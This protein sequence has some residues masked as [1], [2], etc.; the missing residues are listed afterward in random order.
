MAPSSFRLLGR[1]SRLFRDGILSICRSRWWFGRC[2]DH[3]CECFDQLSVLDQSF[4]RWSATRYVTSRLVVSPFMLAISDAA[5]CVSFPR[6]TDANAIERANEYLHLPQEQPAIIPSSRPPAYWPSNHSEAFL[7]VENLTVK[8]A[9]DLPA[10]LKGVSF[11]CKPKEKIGIIGRTGSGKSSLAMALLRFVD[12]DEGK[13]I[14]DGIDVTSI[15]V[16]DLRSK[17]TYI[18]QEAT[19]FSGTVKE[20]LDPFNEHSEEELVQ[21][22]ERVNLGQKNGVSAGPSRVPSTMNL[23]ASPGDGTETPATVVAKK[24]SITLDTSVSANGSNF[25]AGQRQLLALARA[26]LRSSSLIIADEATSSID[27][28]TDNLIQEAIRTDFKESCT[29]TIAHRLTTVADMDKILVLADGGVAEFDSP[30]ELL[31]NESSVFHQMCEHSGKFQQLK[32]IAEQT[33]KAKGRA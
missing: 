4:C 30:W 11:V 9:P 24:A 16:D 7:R 18:N 29:I 10:V 32:D 28:E 26:L 23:G 5:C 2:S 6:C 22:L 31:K 12:P 15:G 19:I 25:S 27:F 20:N 1:W 33:A 17:I 14:L 8:Y 3:L 21:I 13:I